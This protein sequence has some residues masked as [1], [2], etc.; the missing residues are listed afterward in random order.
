MKPSA[1]LSV[2]FPPSHSP[3]YRLLEDMWNGVTYRRHEIPQAVDKPRMGRMVAELREYGWSI[4]MSIQPLPIADQS[5]RQVALYYV[6][7]STLQVA[8]GS[9]NNG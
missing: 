8:M 5:E 3:E 2:I 4:T 6:E 1:N 7:D 9:Q